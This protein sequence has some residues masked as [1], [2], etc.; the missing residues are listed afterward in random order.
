ML[1]LPKSSTMIQMDEKG[2]I[3]KHLERFI[4]MTIHVP[5]EEVKNGHIYQV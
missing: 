5:H 4:M 1:A 2:V 3:A